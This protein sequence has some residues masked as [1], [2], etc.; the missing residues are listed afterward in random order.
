MNPL[1]RKEIRLIL[2]FWVIAIFLAVLPS[3]LLPLEPWVTSLNEIIFW[4]LGFGGVLLGLATFGQEFGLGTFQSLLAQPMERRQMWKAKILTALLG[5]VLVWAVFLIASH[6][7]LDAAMRESLERFVPL[8]RPWLNNSTKFQ[9]VVQGTRNFY[10]TE[11]WF[12]CVGGGVVLILVGLV[13][14]FWTSLLF[15]QTGAAI[16]F[17]ILIPGAI[18][19]ASEIVG[20]LFMFSPALFVIPAFILYVIAGFVFARR[21]FF[22]AQDAQWLGGTISLSSM[23]S[24]PAQKESAS[25]RCRKPLRALLRKEFQ[26]HQISLLIAFGL[27]VLHIVTLIFR[28]FNSMTLNSELRF[29]VEAV[30]LLWL[31]L[32]WVIGSVAV[33]EERKLGV[34]E[35]QLCLPVSRRL[36]FTVKLFVVLLL[37]IVLGGVMPC[38]VESVGISAGVRSEIVQRQAYSGTFFATVAEV[39][40]GAGI[41]AFASFYASTLTRNTLTALGAVVPIGGVFFAVLMWFGATSGRYDYSLWRGPLVFYV[42]VPVWVLAVMGLSFWNYKRLHAGRNVWLRNIV[43]LLIASY[44]SCLAAAVIY[45]RPE[46]L[47]VPVEPHHGA[48]RL[49]GSVRPE[50]TTA[51]G[52]VV[53]LLPDGRVWA[54]THYHWRAINQMTQVWDSKSKSN[55]MERVRIP[56]PIGGTFIPG[57]NWVALAADNRTADVVGLQSD[58][59]LWRLLSFQDGSNYRSA[60]IEATPE[61]QRIGAD[62]DWKSI[63]SADDC[64]MAVKTNGTLWGWG[65]NEQ[66]RFPDPRQKID[67]PILIDTNADWASV[68]STEF[69]PFF[70]KQNG[71][72]WR[73]LKVPGEDQVRLFRIGLNMTNYLSVASTGQGILMVDRDGGL[74]GMGRLPR[75]VFGIRTGLTAGNESEQFV[76]LGHDSDWRQVSDNYAIKGGRLVKNDSELFSGSL[77]RPSKYSD[78]IAIDLRWDA[79]TAFSADGTI[80]QWRDQRFWDPENRLL[81][82]TRRPVW[83]FNIFSSLRIEYTP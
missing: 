9:D 74:W 67:E 19:V 52:R 3:V 11:F 80:C 22:S 16:W 57:S 41:I 43:V 71:D 63:A 30:P 21:M 56:V 79:F 49:H 82:P 62:S 75:R 25:V 7:R 77:G 60:W 36:Q 31:M 2:P 4:A 40:L 38:L 39:I 35:G 37:G 46:E 5:G 10:H 20:H 68:I 81:S 55:R 72:A 1:V 64:F 78:W 8:Q 47:A 17:S 27:L 29:A 59:T 34:M 26:S 44:C 83:S 76:R 32:P 70:V 13:G 58:G 28:G 33:A 65:R 24:K 61:P 53:A 51:G 6:F 69:R 48:A 73:W 15:R 42:V 18:L 66:H 23:G 50:I 45:Q 12:S 54:A 14:G